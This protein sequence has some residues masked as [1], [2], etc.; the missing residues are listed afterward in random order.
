MSEEKSFVYEEAF[1]SHLPGN[2]ELYIGKS[3]GLTDDGDRIFPAQMRSD[4]KVVATADVLFFRTN[5]PNAIQFAE[6]AT[7][8]AEGNLWARTANA[9]ISRNGVWLT[10]KGTNS[11]DTTGFGLK[12]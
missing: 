1:G 11:V 3:K 7:A 12:Q 6:K 9:R 2:P 8:D 5:D 4:D 10:L